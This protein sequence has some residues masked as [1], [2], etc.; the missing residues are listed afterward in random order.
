MALFSSFCGTSLSNGKEFH[1]PLKV[2]GRNRNYLVAG[3]E[4][5]MA[6]SE[7]FCGSRGIVFRFVIKGTSHFQTIFLEL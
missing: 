6:S 4:S 2:Q 7:L 1:T 3:V 5:E